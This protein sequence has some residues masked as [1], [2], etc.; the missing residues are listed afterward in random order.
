MRLDLQAVHC[1]SWKTYVEKTYF[2]PGTEELV[3]KDLLSLQGCELGLPVVKRSMR[4]VG[5]AL[6]IEKI[7]WVGLRMG[8]MQHLLC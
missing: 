3:R 2:G 4:A 6:R 8:R 5:K 7:T 1:W